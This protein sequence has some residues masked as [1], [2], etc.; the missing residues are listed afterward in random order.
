MTK[1]LIFLSVIIIMEL[2][3]FILLLI[4]IRHNKWQK[5]NPKPI[6]FLKKKI[7]KFN[8]L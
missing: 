7:F 5:Q 4:S 8:D 2:I 1:D 6:L 3:F